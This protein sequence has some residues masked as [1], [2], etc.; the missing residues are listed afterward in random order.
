M[1]IRAPDGANK[2]ILWTISKPLEQE[3]MI[4]EILIFD[5]DIN[6]LILILMLIFILILILID[7]YWFWYCPSRRYRGSWVARLEL[8]SESAHLQKSNIIVIMIMICDLWYMKHHYYYRNHRYLHQ[9]NWS[10]F[11]ILCNCTMTTSHQFTTKQ[12]EHLHPQQG[13]H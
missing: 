1:A 4:M 12:L 7:W 6:W 5:F 2:I 8:L 9:Q 10:S 13:D 3:R 11:L